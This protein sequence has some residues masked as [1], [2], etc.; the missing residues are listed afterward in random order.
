MLSHVW[1]F[2]TSW[3]VACQALLSMEFSRQEYCSQLPFLLPGNLPNPGI[4]PGSSALQADSLPSEPPGKFP[5]SLDVSLFFQSLYH[6]GVIS[7]ENFKS[8]EE[9]L[10]RAPKAALISSSQRQGQLTQPSP[11][12]LWL[13]VP[14][15]QKVDARWAETSNQNQPHMLLLHIWST[16]G[17]RRESREGGW[18]GPALQKS[19]IPV[20]QGPLSDLPLLLFP[21]THH[22]FIKNF[23]NTWIQNWQRARFQVVS[24]L[25]NPKVGLSSEPHKAHIPSE[26][27]FD[28]IAKYSAGPE[29]LVIVLHQR[30]CNSC[31]LW[32]HSPSSFHAVTLYSLLTP[33]YRWED[34]FFSFMIP[35]EFLAHSCFQRSFQTWRDAVMQSLLILAV[36]FQPMDMVL[37]INSKS[38]ASTS[39]TGIKITWTTNDD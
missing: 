18:E 32:L 20:V 28:W 19:D 27:S 17:M 5:H 38:L 31:Y 7:D 29:F 37:I 14:R 8:S 10:F 22:P 4:E 3:T 16:F 2:A 30:P 23:W 1:V 39:V 35:S 12:P 24:K 21:E 9:W 36:H 25:Q 6:R 11:T 33:F 13:W 15:N 34:S 26:R